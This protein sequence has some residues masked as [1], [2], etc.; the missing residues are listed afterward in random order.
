MGQ[1][2]RIKYFEFRETIIH[3]GYT[4]APIYKEFGNPYIEGSW[5]ILP[6][7]IFGVHYVEWLHYCEAQGA[8]LIGKNQYYV[9]PVW[10]EP[11]YEILNELNE[12]TNELASLIDLKGLEY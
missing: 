9:M 10:S 7:R 5:L 1:S 3:S 6:A 11:N 2:S 4:I 8:R 12:R